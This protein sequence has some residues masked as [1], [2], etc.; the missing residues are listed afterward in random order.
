LKKEL[1]TTREELGR[2]QDASNNILSRYEENEK[3]QDSL[4]TNVKL[5]Q[6]KNYTAN[7]LAVNRRQGG[8]CEHLQGKLDNA[9]TANESLTCPIC[10]E[11]F[12][13]VISKIKKG[14]KIIKNKSLHN[15]KKLQILVVH[16]IA[17]M[18]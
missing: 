4:V 3:H 7:A 9:L 1:A 15:L 18:F 6:Q 16:A 8:L 12:S 5:K 14:T 2:V 13:E 10:K 11:S 17:C